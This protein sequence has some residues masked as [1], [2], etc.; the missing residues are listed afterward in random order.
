MCRRV[1]A[2][3]VQ[4]TCHRKLYSDSQQ[5]LYAA[6][7]HFPEELKWYPSLQG[8]GSE[9]NIQIY[10]EKKINTCVKRCVYGSADL[11]P[12]ASACLREGGLWG[13]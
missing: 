3:S 8:D 6:E 7:C 13:G 12:A 1:S 9:K 10:R 5:S 11:E 4:L 2:Q